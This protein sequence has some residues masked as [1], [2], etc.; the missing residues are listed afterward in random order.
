MLIDNNINSVGTRLHCSL[1]P[2]NN[3]KTLSHSRGIMATELL[4]P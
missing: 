4:S 1:L 2:I 3:A